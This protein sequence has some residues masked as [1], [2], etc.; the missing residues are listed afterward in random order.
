MVADIALPTA[1]TARSKKVTPAMINILARMSWRLLSEGGLK[2]MLTSPLRVVFAQ[3]DLND[4]GK[5]SF[6]EWVI[7][8]EVD[9]GGARALAEHWL[10]FDWEDKG[11]LTYTEAYERKA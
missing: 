5:I 2:T 6:G 8:Q 4:D 10:K 3:A 1:S 11:Y 7:S 9:G